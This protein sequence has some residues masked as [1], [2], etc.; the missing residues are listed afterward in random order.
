LIWPLRAV[1]AIGFILLSLQA[2]AE[3][4]RSLR[5]LATGVDPHAP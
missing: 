5:M 4:V 2:I 3:L 1:F